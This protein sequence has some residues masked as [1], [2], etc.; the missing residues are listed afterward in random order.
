MNQ[1]K[2]IGHYNIIQPLDKGGMGEMYLAEDTKLKHEVAIIV[3]SERLR[4]IEDRLQRFIALKKKE[5]P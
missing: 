4:S 3:L 2:N 1:G 5:K